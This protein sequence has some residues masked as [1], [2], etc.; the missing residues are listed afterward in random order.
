MN[1]NKQQLPW[2][3]ALICLLIV[4]IGLSLISAFDHLGPVYLSDEVGY[5]AKAAHLA[6]HSNLLSSSWHAGYSLAI[7]PLFMLFG[8]QPGVWIGVALLNLTLLTASIGLWT[9]TLRRLGA[10]NKQATL[11]SLSSLVC[12][13]VWGFTGWI[14]VNPCMQLIIAMMSRWLLIQQRFRQLLAITLTGGLAYWLHPTGLLISA[15]AWLVVLADL[16]YFRERITTRSAVAIIS[17]ILLTLVLTLFYAIAHST[18]NASMG[19]DAGHYANQI[20][21]YLTELRQDTRNT[22]AEISTGLINGLANLSISTY[23]YSMLLAA[24]MRP[25]NRETDNQV[26]RNQAKA[27]L[28]IATTSVSLL[29]FSSLLAINM[30]GD[31]QHMFHQRYTAPVIQAL[32]ILG[33]FRW[34]ERE[35][36]MNLPTRLTLSIS[37][38]LAALIAGSALWS[39]NKRFSIIDAMSS[40][41]SVIAN[42]LG[43]EQE[44]LAGLA[45]G[46]L[47]IITIQT[48]S[49]RPKLVIAGIISSV[50]GSVV[51]G[52]R[53]DMLSDYS[54]KP[55]LAP[56]I[57][58]LSKEGKVCLSAL[59]TEL[60]RRESERLYEFYLS[61]PRITRLRSNNK[62]NI[63]YNSFYKPDTNDCDYIVAPIDLP[64]SKLR[65]DL[66]PIATT[67]AKCQLASVDDNYGWGIYQCKGQ[68]QAKSGNAQPGFITASN[69][70]ATGPLP[71]ELRPIRVYNDK[72]LRYESEFINYGRMIERS[73]KVLVE[74]CRTLANKPSLKR[75]KKRREVV[76]AN[77]DN[78]PLLWGLYVD[79]FKAGSYRLQASGLKVHKGSVTIEIINENINRISSKTF[80]NSSKISPIPFKIPSDELRFEVRLLASQGSEFQP[81]THLI[82]SQ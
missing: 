10:S 9:S 64:L 78:A 1:T 26:D 28:F 53:G 17:G 25:P 54:A 5:A 6:G 56:N 63:E 31:Y 19:G 7:T 24:G 16:V 37:P 20:T 13:S 70:I 29:L 43:S 23:G 73:G 39:Y 47:F 34:M 81:P 50:V 72:A 76:I 21:G 35:K 57:Q 66:K 62:A 75:C 45:I 15:C 79:S 32:W 36:T 74:P 27:T 80:E 48:L 8:V 11:I 65:N 59:R 33:S 40:G 41:S 14:F 71:T 18:I 67:L 58:A 38:V 68:L 2:D 4:Y 44:A 77:R 49:W 12:F 82:F 61:S 3:H 46:C 51:S 69:R 52:R 55:I 22:L 60:S 42:N 30:A